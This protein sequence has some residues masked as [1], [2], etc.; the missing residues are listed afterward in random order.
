MSWLE[1]RVTALSGLLRSS[2]RAFIA[3]PLL[4]ALLGCSDSEAARDE[5]ADA[6]ATSNEEFAGEGYAEFDGRRDSYEGSRGSF[7]G[8][9]CTQDC[10]GHEAGY[11][12]AEEKGITDPDHCGGKSWSFIEGCRAYA[13]QS[14]EAETSEGE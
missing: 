10:S 12:W 11:A 3:T 7:E 14:S 5:T 9:G 13:E 2:R 1:N 4:V 8:Y 6:L